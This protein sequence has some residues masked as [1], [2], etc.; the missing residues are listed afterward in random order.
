MRDVIVRAQFERGVRRIRQSLELLQDLANIQIAQCHQSEPA[1]S[2][3]L[4]YTRPV[5]LKIIKR[6]DDAHK[7]GGAPALGRVT[8][9]TGRRMVWLEVWN[10]RAHVMVDKAL[11]KNWKEVY[12]MQDVERR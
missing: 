9:T 5:C 1:L 3:Q 8:G 11:H 10:G 2:P 12:P 7:Y 4:P 6:V